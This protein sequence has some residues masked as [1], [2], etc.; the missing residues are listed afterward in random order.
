[1]PVVGT[2]GVC[3]KAVHQTAGDF[4]M[5]FAVMALLSH[6]FGEFGVVPTRPKGPNRRVRSFFFKPNRGSVVALRWLCDAG[7]LRTPKR[8]GGKKKMRVRTGG[9]QEAHARVN[10]DM[11]HSQQLAELPRRKHANPC[12]SLAMV[13]KS[14]SLPAEVLSVVLGFVTPRGLCSAR[15]AHRCFHVHDIGQVHR[16]FRDP[17]W[18][19]ISLDRACRAGRVDIIEFL[20][21]RKRIPRTI[22]AI[23][24]AVKAGNMNALCFVQQR[25]THSFSRAIFHAAQIGRLD[26]VQFLY[27]RLDHSELSRL[28]ASLW[29][30]GHGIM[31]DQAAEGGHLDVVRIVLSHAR[32]CDADA[33]INSALVNGRIDIVRAIIESDMPTWDAGLAFAMPCVMVKKKRSTSSWTLFVHVRYQSL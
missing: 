1:M 21:A 13:A 6:F 31:L 20:Y 14:I 11:I 32:Y 30:N 2:L 16:R 29:A 8:N 4:G 33:A 9:Q 15:A 12:P 26:M 3:K 23:M 17:L 19:R 25:D 5:P 7:P 18:M 22:N 24:V 27:E 28:N 10:K